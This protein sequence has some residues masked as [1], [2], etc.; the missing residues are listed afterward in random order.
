MNLN[1]NYEGFED[2][3]VYM[4]PKNGGIQYQFRFDNNYGASVIKGPYSYGGDR[5]LWELAVIS[6]D[7]G[8]YEIRYDTDITSDVEGYLED[9]E[10][11]DLLKQIKELK[12]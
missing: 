12:K 1:L 9:E 2:Y 7:R 5:D 6:W 4:K 8:E 10:V 11:R 3:L